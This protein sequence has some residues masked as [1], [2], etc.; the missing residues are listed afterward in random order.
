MIWTSWPWRPCPPTTRFSPPWSRQRP[1]G[2]TWRGRRRRPLPPRPRRHHPPPAADAA[3]AC[4][5]LFSSSSAQSRRTRRRTH[6]P[7]TLRCRAR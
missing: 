2:R 3:G 6:A 5:H 7:C 1:I 4:P